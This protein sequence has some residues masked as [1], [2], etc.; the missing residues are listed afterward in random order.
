VIVKLGSH[1]VTDYA[2]LLGELRT[3][4]PG[5]QVPVTVNR[6]GTEKTLT[7]TIGSR[8]EQ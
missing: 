3:T 1:R 5:S 4:K 2:D 6:G 7:V 8:T